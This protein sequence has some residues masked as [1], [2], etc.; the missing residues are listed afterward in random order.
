MKDHEQIVD[1]L[2]A[3]AIE[4]EPAERQRFFAECFSNGRTADADAILNKDLVAEVQALLNAYELAEAQKFLQEPLM[5]AGL[6]D[7]PTL[8]GQQ[9]G[10]YTILNLIEAGGMGEVY[11]AADNELDRKVAIKLIKGN[12]KTKEILQ[13]FYSERQIL[14]N[15]KHPNIAGLLEAGATPDGLPFFVMEYVEGRPINKFADE[16]KLSITG[17]LKL[18]RAVCSAVSYAHQNLVV[19]RDLKP[20]NILV[21][22]DGTPKLLDFGIAKL[23]Q[24]SDAPEPDATITLLRIMTPE[25]ASPEQIKG[26]PIKTTTDVYSLGVLLYELLTGQRPYQLRRKT[27][28]EIARAI[29]EQEPE[30]PSQAGRK[31]KA[32]DRKPGA[33]THDQRI[34]ETAQLTVSANPQSEIRNLK[35]LRGDLDNIVLRAMRK[36]PE[37]RYASVE[38]FSEDIHRH[39]EALPVIARKDTLSYRTSKFVQ[40]NK[41]RVAAAVVVLSTLVGGIVTTTWQARLADRRFNQVRKL[42][43]SVLFD[44]HDAIADLPGST[45]VRRR[46]VKDALEYLDGLSQE[47]RSDT[48]LRLELANAYLK[49]GDVQGKPYK[50]NLGDTAGALASYRKAQAIL[51]SLLRSEPSDQ[52]MR[53]DLSITYENIGNIQARLMQGKEAVESQRKSLALR[54]GLLTAEPTN[55]EYRR[56]LADSYFYLGDALTPGHS[57]VFNNIAWLAALESF[58]KSLPLREQLYAADPSSELDGRN[59]AQS[60]QRIGIMLEVGANANNDIENFRAS[61]ASHRKSVII[62]EKLVARDPN[63]AQTRRDLADEY[64]MKASAQADAGDA[65][66]ALADCRKAL[67]VFEALAAGDPTNSE[68]RRDMGSAFYATGVVLTKMKNPTEAAVNFRKEI[69]I[70]EAMIAADPTNNE[71]YL[72]VASGYKKLGETLEKV[73]DRQGAI[74]TDRKLSLIADK[75]AT[76]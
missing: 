19:H 21:T 56:L 26:E 62:R 42:A 34:N 68:A 28:A 61:L 76:K 70:F 71:N 9:L 63:S 75:L 64:V 51:E 23:L 18:F 50:P 29:C 20:S 16:E 2:F 5:T 44:Y 59:L 47:A 49:V 15:L 58:R 33:S 45:P 40:R 14:A 35:L 4:I 55:V 67:V 69:Q 43:H 7:E 3:R 1:E 39:L 17:R 38:Q 41:L 8:V 66:G 60:Y 32:E 65:A 37:R 25:Y 10:G 53:R 6:E 24:A 57:S 52:Q 11:L 12:Q 30:K 36:D 72:S 22:K 46:L 74:E 13:R 48:S 73:G 54:E 31:Q 27:A